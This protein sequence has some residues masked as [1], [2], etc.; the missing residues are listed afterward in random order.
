MINFDQLTTTDIAN[1]LQQHAFTTTYDVPSEI[2]TNSHKEAGVLV[3]FTQIAGAWH[4]VFIRRPH[5]PH[6]RH[7]GQVAFAGGKREPDDTDLIHTALREA[8][9]EIGL[10]PHDVKLLG[11]LGTHHSISRYRISPIVASIPWPYD[12]RLSPSEVARIFTIPLHWLAQPQHHEIRYHHIPN[13][14]S[15]IPVVYFQEYDHEML[16]AAT[17]RMTLSLLNCLQYAVASHAT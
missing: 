2:A 17:A 7:S 4:L 12:F 9:E 5:S 16:W 13:V 10:A 8:E 1:C 11:Q 15:P 14:Q 6:D 3:P